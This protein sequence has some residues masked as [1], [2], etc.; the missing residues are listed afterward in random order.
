MAI[1]VVVSGLLLLLWCASV[2]LSRA[3]KRL[4]DFNVF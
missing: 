2:G 1:V 4:R 3:S